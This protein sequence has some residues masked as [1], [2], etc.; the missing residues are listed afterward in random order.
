MER[1]WVPMTFF[2]HVFV[3]DRLNSLLWSAKCF[4]WPAS[5]QLMKCKYLGGTVVVHSALIGARAQTRGW[6][7]P[8]PVRMFRTILLCPY[9][10]ER[11]DTHF[12]TLT[13]DE[14][15]GLQ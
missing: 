14:G 4:A 3:R 8:V 11:A 12:T 5:G 2:Y 15:L 10:L 9:D 6:L 1:I 13:G 7:A